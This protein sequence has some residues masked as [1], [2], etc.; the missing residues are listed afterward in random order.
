MENNDYTTPPK[1]IILI[2]GCMED[3]ERAKQDSFIK[4]IYNSQQLFGGFSMNKPENAI[5]QRCKEIAENCRNNGKSYEEMLSIV[6]DFYQKQL[7]YEKQKELNKKHE[8][9]IFK[10]QQD[11]KEKRKKKEVKREIKIMIVAA[12]A[13]IFLTCFGWYLHKEKVAYN[14]EY[15]R[16][17]QI[18]INKKY[19]EQMAS[20][21][22]AVNKENE[23]TE[24]DFTVSVSI[25][26][27]YNNSVGDDWYYEFYINGI[28]INTYETNIMHAKFTD[29]FTAE[30]YYC[31]DDNYP[32]SG[33]TKGKHAFTKEQ[34]ISGCEIQQ[35]TVIR[36]NQGRYT[37]NTARWITTYKIKAIMNYP[38]K[39]IRDE[40]SISEEE[41]KE[42]MWK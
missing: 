24:S 29:T 11:Q 41:I 4:D 16:V 23:K 40:I 27:D 19:N 28:P 26:E 10:Q 17:E 33:Y 42:N 18:L 14:E 31:E 3:L 21:H 38:D 1:T 7:A 5:A 13:I 34:L 8:Q 20:Y 37:G 15:A 32:D 9:E 22:K 39:P 36:E 30:S 6:N 35:K 2:D 25:Y 12:C